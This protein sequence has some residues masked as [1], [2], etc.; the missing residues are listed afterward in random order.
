MKG[1]GRF[2]VEARGGDAKTF[3]KSEKDPKKKSPETSSA[4]AEL[5]GKYADIYVIFKLE[6][7]S[8]T[9]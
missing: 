4:R 9:I 1:I 2:A 6:L 3:R 8:N 5:L 7:S